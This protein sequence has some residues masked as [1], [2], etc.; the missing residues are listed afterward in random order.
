MKDW[1]PHV[2]EIF[3]RALD[4]ESREAQQTFLDEVCCGDVDLRANVE[5]L[6]EAD[7]QASRFLERPAGDVAATIDQP[8]FVAERP[9]TQIGPYKLVQE[10]GEDRPD[11]IR[12]LCYLFFR[13]DLQ[14]LRSLRA[15]P[16]LSGDGTGKI[17]A[18]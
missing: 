18:A 1:D 17:V 5:S 9:G 10:I 12:H 4:H 11:A 16:H 3:L 13:R 6:L 2:N 15:Q 14:L 7:R 8:A